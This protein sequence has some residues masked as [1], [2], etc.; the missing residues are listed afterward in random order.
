MFFRY[1]IRTKAILDREAKRY[2]NFEIDAW[3]LG[4]PSLSSS[5]TRI[6][7][8]VDENDND[9]SFGKDVYH[10]SVKENVSPGSIIAPLKADDDDD[11]ENARVTYSAVPLESGVTVPFTINP[12]TGE[13]IFVKG[14]P[15]LD[16]ENFTGPFRL[17]VIATD[18][19]YPKR[20]TSTML[21]VSVKL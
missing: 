13:V 14:A 3:D 18:N 16:A 20:N 19:G 17:R 15:P 5:E 21:E 10:L 6:I 11:G 7:E 8:L 12:D 1:V 9:P 4:I 2:H